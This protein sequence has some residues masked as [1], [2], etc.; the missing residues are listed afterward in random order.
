[1]ARSVTVKKT[2]VSQPQVPQALLSPPAPV[3]ELPVTEEQFKQSF[4]VYIDCKTEIDRLEK[5]QDATKPV[6]AKYVKANGN[7]EKPF[8]PDDAWLDYNGYRVYNQFNPRWHDE[9]GVKW[10]QDQ[11]KRTDLTDAQREELKMLL[12]PTTVLNREL[13]ESMRDRNASPIPEGVRD[14]VIPP[15]FKVYAREMSKKTCEKCGT[16]VA[17]SFNFCPKCGMPLAEQFENA[18]KAKR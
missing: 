14:K 6:L 15:S 11:L 5:R 10:V 9:P 17:K 13:W 3:A 4:E 12:V 18:H 7:H 2:E 8:V 1:M 16:T